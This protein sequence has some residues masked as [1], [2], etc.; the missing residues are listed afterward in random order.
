MR[1]WSL[2]LALVLAF[3]ASSVFAESNRMNRR[4]SVMLSGSDPMPVFVGV[5]LS[6]QLMDFVQFQF[7]G[8]FDSVSS[9]EGFASE[10][11]T[12]ATAAFAWLI[13]L[14]QVEFQEIKD[15]LNESSLKEGET[16]SRTLTAMAGGLNFTVPGWNFS[17]LVGVYLGNWS[18]KNS[19][20]GLTNYGNHGYMKVGIDY[21][22]EKPFRVGIGWAHAPALPNSIENR[23]YGYMG[24][25][26]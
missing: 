26:F 15:F 19:P 2:V 12:T 22:A 10:I 23:L 25:S 4:F 18:A 9:D 13:L 5:N 20:H 11:G 1:S 17:P 3:Q 8:G 6:Y 24:A 16:V 7:G 21:Q 14:G